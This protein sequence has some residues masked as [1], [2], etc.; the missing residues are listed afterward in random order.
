MNAKDLAERLLE[1]PE[2]EVK[3]SVMHCGA[4]TFPDVSVFDIDG[5][6][7]IGHSDSIV[8]LDLSDAV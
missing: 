7:D 3:A 5:I 6:A 4:H 1:H 2:F 8:M